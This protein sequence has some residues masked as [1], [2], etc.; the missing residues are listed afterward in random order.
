L[1]CEFLSIFSSSMPPSWFTPQLLASITS[2]LG[3]VAR[4]HSDPSPILEILKSHSSSRQSLGSNAVQV[5]SLVEKVSE[6]ASPET[7]ASVIQILAQYALTDIFAIPFFETLLYLNFTFN[8]QVS[9]AIGKLLSSL[10]DPHLISSISQSIFQKHLDEF[11]LLFITKI[12]YYYGSEKCKLYKFYSKFDGLFEEIQ[13]NETGMFGLMGFIRAHQD[14]NQ[15]NSKLVTKLFEGLEKCNP[16]LR[17][18]IVGEVVA[19]GKVNIERYMTEKTLRGFIIEGIETL[20]S[21][22]IYLSIP[23]QS[24][25]DKVSSAYFKSLTRITHCLSN[26]L[27]VVVDDSTVNEVVEM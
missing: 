6:H 2:L 9:L 12:Y 11:Q 19:G 26:G 8:Q 22:N 23:R 24:L 14:S 1:N 4:S 21:S 16:A 25:A 5:Y 18:F 7:N 17:V 20:F 27:K 15:H 10:G 13:V 3:T